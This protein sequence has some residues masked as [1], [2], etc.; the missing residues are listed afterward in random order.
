MLENSF[1]PAFAQSRGGVNGAKRARCAGTGTRACETMNQRKVVRVSVSSGVAVWCDRE[2]RVPRTNLILSTTV[3][4]H[5]ITGTRI[6]Q[7]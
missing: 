5:Q 6:C 2:R 7:A 1:L 3:N 4:A